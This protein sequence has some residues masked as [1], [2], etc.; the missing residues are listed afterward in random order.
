MCPRYMTSRYATLGAVPAAHKRVTVS[1][2]PQRMMPVQGI[3]KDEGVLQAGCRCPS[4]CGH[5]SQGG[6]TLSMPLA[7]MLIW[8][9][10]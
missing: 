3:E 6:L 5:S 7:D 2:T 1:P 4:L 9:M 8:L 10:L